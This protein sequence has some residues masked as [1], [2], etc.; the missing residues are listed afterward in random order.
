M[1]KHSG[2]KVLKTERLTLRPFRQDDAEAVFRGWANDEAVT[3]F[4]TWTP[5]RTAEETRAV[6]ALWEEEAKR[7]DV[8]HWA[9]EAVGELIGDINAVATDERTESACI[10]YCLAHKH[11]GKG[12]MTEA[13]FAVLSYLFGEVGFNRVYSS[14]SAENPGSGRVMEK[15]G[16]LYEGTFRQS[17]RLLSTGE[18]TDIVHRAALREEWLS[19]KPN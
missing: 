17:F 18:L 7:P 9:I 4:L 12:I 19:R 16:L 13:F 1:L 8:Y 14:H 3:K 5:H 11:W 10:G 15:C 6:L 2:S